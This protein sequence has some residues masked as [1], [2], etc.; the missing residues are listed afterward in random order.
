[1]I[2][3]PLAVAYFIDP[4]L[5]EGFDSYTQIETQ[6]ISLGQSVVDAYDFYQH[7]HNSYVLT[8]TDAL[9][10]MQFFFSRVLGVK[11]EASYAVLEQ[12]MVL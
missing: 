5:C 6:G 8:K 4:T 2:N 7:K 9:R 3:D 12:I 1:M 11:E 10:F